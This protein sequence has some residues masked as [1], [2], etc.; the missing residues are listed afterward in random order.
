MAELITLSSS[1]DPPK[2]VFRISLLAFDW[3][4]QTI[5]IQ[6]REYNPNANQQ[7]TPPEPFFGSRM[8]QA[9]YT[10]PEAVSLMTTLNKINL[11]TQSLHQRVMNKL[12][13]DGKIPAGTA[14]GAPD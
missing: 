2:T 1:I 8:I 11:S 7:A 5:T 12:L 4:N 3:A 9:A 14:S 13:A 10:G 6:L